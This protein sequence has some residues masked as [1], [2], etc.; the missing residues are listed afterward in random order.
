MGLVEQGQIIVFGIRT[1]QR[2]QDR[3]QSIRIVTGAGRE[4]D[5]HA[6]GFE[7]VGFVQAARVQLLGRTCQVL[8]QLSLLAA[9]TR[10][11]FTEQTGERGFAQRFQMMFLVHVRHFVAQHSG[12]FGFIAQLLHHALR[13]DDEATRRGK[14]IDVIRIVDA[15]V[16]GQVRP[17][18]LLGHPQSNFIHVVLQLRIV[19][20]RPRAEQR[21]GHALADLDFLGLLHLAQITHAFDHIAQIHVLQIES[22]A[23]LATGEH[24][25]GNRQGGRQPERAHFFSLSGLPFSSK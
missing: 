24:D 25:R 7:F 9:C 13:D 22:A 12:Q 5:T 14:R 3:G 16:P 2:G 21:L 1:G 4:H 18:R 11:T 19:K 20:Q 8:Y 23:G 15:K 10:H 17:V 6:I